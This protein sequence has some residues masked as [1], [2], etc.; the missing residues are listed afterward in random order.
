MGNFCC[1]G[2]RMDLASKGI[3]RELKQAVH[4]SVEY[5]R[6]D[7]SHSSL[8]SQLKD[9]GTKNY[10]Y[11]FD[12]VHVKNLPSYESDIQVALIRNRATK[13]KF[14]CKTYLNVISSSQGG[15]NNVVAQRVIGQIQLL[16]LVNSH[17]N[18]P[19]LVDVYT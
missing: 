1:D 6:P 4:T 13:K 16:K 14:I 17:P 15:T 12:F 3:S 19:K 10:H 5:E 7:G 18:I 11:I 8:Q 2:K 9:L